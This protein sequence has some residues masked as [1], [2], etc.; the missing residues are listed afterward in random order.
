VSKAV[1]ADLIIGVDTHL[2]THTAALCDARGRLIS[3]LQVAATAAGYGLRPPE[4]C[5][6]PL[7]VGR[8]VG[9]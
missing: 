5:I 2:D 9:V 6:D 1:E 4:W 3:Q 7:G 8:G